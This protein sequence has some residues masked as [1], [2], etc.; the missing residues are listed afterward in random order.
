MEKYITWYGLLLKSWIKR[1]SS[2]IQLAGMVLVVLLI[3]GIKLPD[4][5]NTIVGLCNQDGAFAEEVVQKLET[6]ESVFEFQRYDNPEKMKEAVIRGELEC[7]FI[8]EKGKKESITCISTPI[9]TKAAVAGET[10]YAAF[11]EKYSEE[12]LLEEQEDVFGEKTSEISKVLLD[13]NQEFLEGDQIFRMDFEEVE[14]SQKMPRQEAETFPV[15]GMTALLI[16]VM[17]LMNHGKKFEQK[18]CSFE[19]ALMPR[20]AVCFEFIRYLA[21]AAIPALIGICLM[22]Y[23]GNGAGILRE[24]AGMLVLVLTSAL[25]VVCIG[26]LFRNSITYASWIMTLVIGNLLLCPVFIDLS[27]YL[28]AIRYINCIFP[29]GIYLKLF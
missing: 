27:E 25:W 24:T 16:F 20:E 26:K 7:G 10:V 14:S 4:T 15:R 5:Q 1:K 6:R 18:D 2:W 12:I 22:M 13:K 29:L 28:P 23:N 3:A 9:T 19:K 17:V 11:L 21:G 8:F